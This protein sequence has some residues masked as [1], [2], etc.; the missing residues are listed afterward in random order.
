M[1]TRRLNNAIIDAQK[2]WRPAHHSRVTATLSWFQHDCRQQDSI[3]NGGLIM[4]FAD[5]IGIETFWLS[6]D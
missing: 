4:E 2:T 6:P 1:Q 3:I 5:G